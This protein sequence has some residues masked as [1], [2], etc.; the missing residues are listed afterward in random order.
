MFGEAA[1]CS[2]WYYLG[3]DKAFSSEYNARGL[4]TNG[5]TSQILERELT[6]PK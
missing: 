6:W 3:I 2:A 1:A 4:Q 5:R